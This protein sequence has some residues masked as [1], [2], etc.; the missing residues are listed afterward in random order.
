M[1]DD[2]SGFADEMWEDLARGV[3][4]LDEDGQHKVQKARDVLLGLMHIMTA[5]SPPEEFDQEWY[6]HITKAVTTCLRMRNSIREQI[7]IMEGR[8]AELQGYRE[9]Y[10]RIVH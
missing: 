3:Q 6:D 7:L 4:L 1:T 10:G 5:Q 9:K 2:R 8:E